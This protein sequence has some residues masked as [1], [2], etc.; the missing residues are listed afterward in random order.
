VYLLILG[1][2]LQLVLGKT[3]KMKR[4]NKIIKLFIATSIL[5]AQEF[6]LQFSSIP[7]GQGI[8]L[9][10]S[11]KVL[12]SI[13]GFLSQESSSESFKVGDGFLK[14][15]Q[16]IF[17]EPPQI[18]I[19]NFPS[20]INK[21]LEGVQ[22]EVTLFDLNGIKSANLHL[23]LG[24][25][26]NEI[27]IPM[28]ENVNN[29]F[30]TVI[31][32]T[33]IDITNF[34]ARVFAEDNLGFISKSG[35]K[36]GSINFSNNE[37]TMSDK[38]SY[39]P[40]GIQSGRWR[41]I[42]WPGIPSDLSLAESNL[43]EGHVFYKYDPTSK[44]YIIP[45]SIEL[46]MGYWFK[47]N[48]KDAV[49][50]DEDTSTSIPLENYVINLEPGWNMIGSPFSFPVS[51]EKDSI[52]GDLITFG[53]G[54]K[55]GWST[56]QN[57]LEPWNGYAVFSQDISSIKITPFEE[58]NQA[59]S[60]VLA[61]EGWILNIKLDSESYFNYMTVIGR[62]EYAKNLTDNYDIPSPKFLEN[63]LSIASSL[64]GNNSYQYI[65]DIRSTEDFNGVWDL[66]LSADADQKNITISIF[67]N[68]FLPEE[69]Y[70]S[71][72]DIQN[73]FINYEILKTASIVE[74]KSD[75]KSFDYK[76]V[77]GDKNYVIAT[78]EEILKNIP[79]KYSL[80]QNYPNP[81]NP[82]TNLDY[83]LPKRS[84]VQI[85]IYNVLG[86]QVK[87]LLDEEQNYGSHSIF[88]DGLD[89]LG[90]EVSTGVYFARMMT[91]SFTQTKKMLLLK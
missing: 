33:L 11:I 27:I 36:T 14:S 73:R 31:H 70:F 45:K 35:F 82:I 69:L 49:I 79:D 22:I 53:S 80:S 64:D 26:D 90:N 68:S 42:S 34:R 13:G 55:N 48:Y 56:A 38:Y 23:Q 24:G 77:S 37:M 18:S 59:R 1:N 51:F 39:Y 75:Y 81:F 71:L 40:S 2:V 19:Y 88:W 3:D 60:R 46:G 62:K 29:I 28:I 30:Q 87:I 78:S 16:N 50:F 17:S 84:K 52:I 4:E 91:S 86:Q 7:T 6:K 76:I 83:E 65:N 67:E 89:Q 66:R 9:G 44:E 61:S 5:F 57:S 74:N 41:L 21:D 85:L 32:D 58:E 12:N 10:D 20:I 72:V 43:S 15:S 8:A 25:D 54:E 47:H 63:R